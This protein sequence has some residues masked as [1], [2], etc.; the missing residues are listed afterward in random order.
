MLN[1]ALTNSDKTDPMSWTIR[2]SF[3]TAF[4]R[5]PMT[6]KMHRRMS[7]LQS[8]SRANTY[9]ALQQPRPSWRII[10]RETSPAY[11]PR[12]SGARRC[13]VK[14]VDRKL[15]AELSWL[16]HGSVPCGSTLK[17]EK[18]SLKRLDSWQNNR[19]PI[20]LPRITCCWCFW[21]GVNAAHASAPN[22]SSIVGSKAPFAGTGTSLSL[23]PSSSA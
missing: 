6:A 17:G 12:N 14:A 13:Y 9:Y 16:E 18:G 10:A 1:M 22:V 2:R 15:S 3:S 4:R 5:F 8:G 21:S 19:H 20:D 11:T 23:S 7:K